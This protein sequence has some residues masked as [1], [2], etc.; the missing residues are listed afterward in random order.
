MA[1]KIKSEPNLKR[2]SST[3]K[4]SPVKKK[5]T[6]ITNGASTSGKVGKKLRGSK[7]VGKPVVDSAGKKAGTT[8]RSQ[9]GA[10]TSNKSNGKSQT[11]AT[12]NMKVNRSRTVKTKQLQRFLHLSLQVW[13]GLQG[14]FE[15][16]L[17]P[18]L[19]LQQVIHRRVQRLRF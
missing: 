1:T 7:A 17:A 12:A 3:G 4:K 8:K 9:A 18:T 5:R 6:S 14:G 15:S 19:H 10:K 11:T 16:S 13:T 2:Q